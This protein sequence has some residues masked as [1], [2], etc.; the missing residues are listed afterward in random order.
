MSRP[1]TFVP[2]PGTDRL[3]VPTARGE[4]AALASGDARAPVA[5]LLPGFTGSKE[6][7]LPLL[8]ALGAGGYRVVSVDGRGQ[9]ETEGPESP[10]AYAPEE[11]AADVR[12]LARALGGRAHLL[13]HSLGGLISRAAVIAEPALFVSLTIMSAGPAATSQ[14]QIEKLALLS[15]ALGAMEKG[16]VWEAMAALESPEAAEAAARPA[17]ERDRRLRERWLRTRTVQLLTT[18]KQLATEPDRVEELAASGVPVHV[19]SGESDDTWPVEWLDAMALRLGA[20][21]TRVAGA[22]HSPNT[23]RPKETAE[24]LL[25]FWDAHPAE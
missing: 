18:G 12:A 9:Y 8:P 24:A 3:T 21:R 23:D 4:F 2:P 7:F 1:P 10:E 5:L 16:A 19:V 13:G 17:T 15:Q 20:P 25:A 6:D 22:G 14:G 11:L